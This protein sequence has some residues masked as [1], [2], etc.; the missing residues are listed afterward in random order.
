[1]KFQIKEEWFDARLTYWNLK[2]NRYSNALSLEERNS[3]WLPILVFTNTDHNE[4]TA[5][6]S[7]SEV[8]ITRESDFVHS[9]SDIVEEINIFSGKTNRLTYERIYTKTFRCDYQLQL[10][11]FD[12]QKCFVDISTKQIDKYS[13]ILNPGILKMLG[14]KVLTQYVIKEWKLESL[15]GKNKSESLQITLVLKR[16]IMNQLLTSYFPTFLILIIVYI[17]N[18]FKDF[19]FEAVVTVNLTSLLVLTTLFLSVSGSLPSTAYVKM[20]DV[21]LIFVQLVPFVEV[22]L[23]T[24]MDTLRD[25]EDEG[26]REVNHHGKAVTV[27]SSKFDSLTGKNF[28]KVFMNCWNHMQKSPNVFC[29]LSKVSLNLPHKE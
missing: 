2:R 7:D 26:E 11:P 17:T 13:V 4:V 9:N 28:T 15:D 27:G 16:R 23:H 14:P 1:M 3:I 20:I 22:L 29:R 24:Y 18:Y 6:D 12:T 21:W 25:G 19:F 10:Y 8:T 5:A